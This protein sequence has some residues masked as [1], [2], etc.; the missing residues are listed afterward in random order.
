MEDHKQILGM[1]D[2][3]LLKPEATTAQIIKLCEEAAEYGFASVCVNSSYVP[4]A[5]RLL[6]DS[7]VKVCTVVGFPLGA[8]AA[9]AKAYETEYAIDK[10][11]T[12][13]DMV[14]NIGVLKSRELR[15]LHHD[16]AAVVLACHAYDDVICK[17]IIETA[18]LTEEEKIIACQIA[19]EARADFVKTSTGFSTA[20]ATVEDV[21]LMREVV[22][23]KVGVK[24]AG[25]VRTLA[26]AVAMIEAGANRLGASA[27]VAI[28]KE[29]S[30]EAGTIATDGY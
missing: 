10:G 24:A 2:H 6:A 11:A 19:K 1:I 21:R 25:G 3:T 12:E 5:A 13:I 30:G 22:G 9:A 16:I 28:A 7:P 4:A 20:G 27:G 15:Q 14:I 17:V 8:M 29:I 18:L 23:G 26:D